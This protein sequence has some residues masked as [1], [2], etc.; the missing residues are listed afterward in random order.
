MAICFG[1]SYVR[2]VKSS[3]KLREDDLDSPDQ[4]VTSPD[5]DEAMFLDILVLNLH[6]HNLKSV[7]L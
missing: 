4:R 2:L 5:V 1:L 6:S 7:K 3:P